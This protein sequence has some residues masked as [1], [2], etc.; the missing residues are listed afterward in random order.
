[1]CTLCPRGTNIL[2]YAHPTAGGAD[3]CAALYES[4]TL[5][6]VGCRVVHNSYNAGTLPKCWWS[7]ALSLW[8]T[9]PR[10]RL[11]SGAKTPLRHASS[12]SEVVYMFWAYAFLVLQF[13]NSGTSYSR[14][15]CRYAHGQ[16][17]PATITAAFSLSC[18]FFD[19][20][21]GPMLLYQ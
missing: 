5:V 10:T 2:P 8:H 16:D 14:P 12:G 9:I 3:Y 18:S 13:L 21:V 1:M 6:T 11:P 15:P 7:S 19:M 4:I 20:V 17:E